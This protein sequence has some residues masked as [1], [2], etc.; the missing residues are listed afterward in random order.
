MHLLEVFGYM[1]LFVFQ[2]A[3]AGPAAAVSVADELD[4]VKQ[5]NQLLH[6]EVIA[7][8]AKLSLVASP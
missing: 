7:L 1:F 5:E 2:Q 6:R 8:K 4:R 3:S